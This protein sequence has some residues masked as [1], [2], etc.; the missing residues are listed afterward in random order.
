MLLPLERM[1]PSECSMNTCPQRQGETDPVML[2]GSSQSSTSPS[3]EQKRDQE[4]PTEPFGVR[5]P[6]ARWNPHL[7]AMATPLALNYSLLL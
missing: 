4:V 2:V 3:E 6:G 5:L 1:E 7:P